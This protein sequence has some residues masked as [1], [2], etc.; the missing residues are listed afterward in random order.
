MRKKKSKIIVFTESW[1]NTKYLNICNFYFRIEKM[2]HVNNNRINNYIYMYGVQNT[3]QN[4]NEIRKVIE[5][6]KFIIYCKILYIT[7]NCRIIEEDSTGIT[8]EID[9]MNIEN[10][11]K[12]LQVISLQKKL[13]PEKS[14]KNWTRLF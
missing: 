7:D 3:E 14:K 10:Y 12:I 5:E 11:W 6:R 13:V 4:F 8:I 2:N 9:L 1:E